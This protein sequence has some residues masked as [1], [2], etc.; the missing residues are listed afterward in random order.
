MNRVRA[1]LHA[2]EVHKAGITGKNITAAVLDTGICRHPDYADRIIGFRDFVNKKGMC[3]DDASH[4]THVSGILAGDGRCSAGKYCGIAPGCRLIHLKVLD[5]FGQGN[6]ED[7]I[8]AVK[9]VIH[10]REKYGIRILN[11]SAGTSKSEEEQGAEQLVSWVDKAWDAGIVVVVAA[12][13]KGPLPMSVTVPGTSRKV[14]TVGSSDAFGFR[15]G[16]R[17]TDYSGCGPTHDC[18]CKPE[19]IA[20]GTGIHSCSNRWK[21]RQ[22]YSIKSGTSMAA[23]AVSGGIALLLETEPE[24]TNVEVKMRLKHSAR[25]MGYTGNRQGWGMPDFRVLTGISG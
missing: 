11:L 9:W 5:R 24:L 21:G 3:Y 14:I 15:P 20:P 22:Y 25:D 10:N 18:I 2:D 19:L 12:G 8:E 1:M 4:G 7:I 17:N 6:L 13:N 16:R 23:P